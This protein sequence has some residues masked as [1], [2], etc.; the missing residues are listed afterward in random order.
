ML[1]YTSITLML[2]VFFGSESIREL[3][4]V[5]FTRDTIALL[6]L[7]TAALLLE[8]RYKTDPILL[9]I[10]GAVFGLVFLQ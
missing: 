9:T 7:F 8:F 5:I 4:R 3:H 2:S 10:I 6:I 1:I